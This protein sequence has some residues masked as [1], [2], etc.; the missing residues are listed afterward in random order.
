MEKEWTVKEIA[1]VIGCSKPTVQK[2]INENEI[3][4]DEYRKNRQI[5][6]SSTARKIIEMIK[7]DFDFE[8]YFKSEPERKESEKDGVCSSGET[9][10]GSQNSANDSQSIE[11]KVENIEKELQNIAKNRQEEI[12]FLRE[13]I[14]L[15]DDIIKNLTVKNDTLLATNLKLNQMIEDKQQE[16]QEVIIEPD[17]KQG[18]FRRLFGKKG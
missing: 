16:R 10:N 12:D 7:K 18:F 8:K 2:V 3:V 1:D 9:A 13:Q 15:K 11:K 4:C 17:A 5:F 6:Y 14:R